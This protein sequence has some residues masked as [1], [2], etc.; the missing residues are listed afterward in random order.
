MHD[1]IW[2]QRW[3]SALAVAALM[4]PAAHAAV[5]PLMTVHG[6]LAQAG[7]PVTGPT[8]LT[9]KLYGELAAPT[10]FWEETLTVQCEAG[11]Y[12]AV[13][14]QSEP[15]DPPVLAQV[16]ELW[17]GIVVEAGPE[18]SPRLRV[19]SVP[20]AA[21]ADTAALAADLAC[22]A[23]VGPTEVSFAYAGSASAGG[24]ANELVC[25]GAC[26]ST[27]EL[28]N[29]A[30]TPA[31]LAPCPANG[32]L[33]VTAAGAWACST[34]LAITD[35][36][37]IGIGTTTPDTRLAVHAGSTAGDVLAR[38]CDASGTHCTQLRIRGE[39]A[40]VYG[41]A[42]AGN[43]T[44]TCNGT[45]ATSYS[46]A[47]GEAK[48]CVDTF[49]GADTASGWTCAGYGADSCD[50]NVSNPA[51]ACPAGQTTP[52]TDYT[53]APNCNGSGVDYMYRTFTCVGYQN[54]P[55]LC[56]NRSFELASDNW[57]E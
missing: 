4:A 36:G 31:K 37:N 18:L 22:A 44:D 2:S 54:R 49:D 34:A 50:G 6:R 33:R 12:T 55:V 53:S 40:D 21:A 7:Q 46:C 30:V 47:A 41:T 16:P 51:S 32:L 1:T 56:N 10:A 8:Q 9:F 42:V 52:C 29:A 14:G 39:G 28:D 27:T 48:T 15:L 3:V 11:A 26:V 5:P 23:C 19:T 38:F 35:N 43:V 25:T 17:L 24:P 20:Y 57:Q 45:I 13:L